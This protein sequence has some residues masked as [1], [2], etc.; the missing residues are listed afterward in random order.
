MEQDYYRKAA[1]E[2]MS[3][4]EQLDQLMQ[5]TS[6]VGWIALAT[7]G[8]VLVVVCVWSVLGSIPELVDGQGVLIRG[9]R[10]YEVKA[11]VGG[12]LGELNLRQG[13]TVTAGQVIATITSQPISEEQRNADQETIRRNRV[14]IQSKRM[15]IDSL[16]RQH[17]TLQELVQQGLKP[18]N[19]L[20]ASE[21]QINVARFEQNA[22]ERENANLDARGAL[23]ATMVKTPESG[24]VV[25]VI[26]SRGDT[27]RQGEPLI[28]L[29]QT[30]ASAKGSAL[31][32][33]CGGNVHAIIYLPGSLA[34]KVRP[35]QV[36]RVSPIEV[37]KEEY[38]YIVGEVEF[39]ANHTASV[40]DM[41]EKLKNEPLV[42]AYL[43][44]GPVA[45]ARVCLAV[46]AQNTANG[47]KWS[48]SNGPDKAIGTG[49]QCL[50]S[51]LVDRRR[52]YT[53]II[54]AARRNF[55]L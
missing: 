18:A 10:L 11:P 15:E 25:E 22:L 17:E 42:Q 34:G 54:P 50:V 48:S 24:R 38:G 30:S 32:D 55:G 47:F 5:V 53:Y 6:P 26:K 20:I 40:D 35:R 2:K 27:L 44:G 8:L 19:Q 37:K 39:V 21:R 29:E 16:R 46:D 13:S 52:P 43:K 4:P 49:S 7:T 12:A 51:L 3:S 41:R 9:E 31:A 33:F 14:L 28:R 36:A 1:V 23:I 45:E